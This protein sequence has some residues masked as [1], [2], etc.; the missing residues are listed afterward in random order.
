M[1]AHTERA[2]AGILSARS[3]GPPTKAFRVF[4]FALTPFQRLGKFTQSSGCRDAQAL[5]GKAFGDVGPM[6]T[7]WGRRTSRS[8]R[9][10]RAVRSSPISI[11]GPRNGDVKLC[12]PCRSPTPGES[13]TVAALADGIPGPTCYI[14]STSVSDVPVFVASESDSRERTR[15]SSQINSERRYAS[16]AQVL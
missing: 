7:P 14:V 8:T 15:N 12:R 9:R 3:H 6:K 4:A 1:N 2:P 10:I 16:E 13:N 5:V 11:S